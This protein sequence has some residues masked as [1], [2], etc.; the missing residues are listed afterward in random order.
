MSRSREL[1]HE[2]R[3]HHKVE[4]LEHSECAYEEIILVDVA[5]DAMHEGTNAPPIDKYITLNHSAS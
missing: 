1:S 4:M 5:A 3:S 2:A